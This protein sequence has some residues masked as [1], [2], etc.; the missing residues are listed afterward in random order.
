MKD[1]T[2]IISGYFIVER[3]VCKSTKIEHETYKH[4]FGANFGISS[5]NLGEINN[6]EIVESLSFS[7]NYM[8]ILNPYLFLDPSI[9]YS[10]H[11]TDDIEYSRFSPEISLNF[12]KKVGNDNMIFVGTGPSYQ[13]ISIKKPDMKAS[14]PSFFLQAGYGMRKKLGQ[15]QVKLKLDIINLNPNER[16]YRLSDGDRL[17]FEVISIYISTYG[18]LK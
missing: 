2:Y 15:F 18:I 5:Q 4:G 8:R 10:I 6:N 1:E 13:R 16:S 9:H 17:K 12:Y 3:C 11:S 14:G 7:L